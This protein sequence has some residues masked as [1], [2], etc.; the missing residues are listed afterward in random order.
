MS[1]GRLV[2]ALTP[3]KLSKQV[4]RSIENH[5]NELAAINKHVSQVELAYVRL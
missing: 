5:E 4:T 3:E 1:P 2:E